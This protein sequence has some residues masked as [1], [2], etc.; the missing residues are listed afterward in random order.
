VLLLRDPGLASFVVT[1]ADRGARCLTSGK[2]RPPLN[3]P[4]LDAVHVH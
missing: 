2:H 3:C 1:G 4:G